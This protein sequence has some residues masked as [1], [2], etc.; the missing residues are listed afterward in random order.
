MKYSKQL[1]IIII[2]LMSA[3]LVGVLGFTY[4]SQD[5][6][7]SQ[8][9]VTESS[10]EYINDSI[11]TDSEDIEKEP[12][13][14]QTA[15]ESNEITEETPRMEGEAMNVYTNA[16]FPSL[17]L[18]YSESWSIKESSEDSIFYPGLKSTM[19][20]FRQGDSIVQVTF[21]PPVGGCGGSGATT[22]L[23]P[24]VE[25]VGDSEFHRYE[26]INYPLD[27]QGKPLNE[28]YEYFYT[29][30]FPSDGGLDPVC[31]DTGTFIATTY[32]NEALNS[33]QPGDVANY[34]Y[35]VTANGD[36]AGIL[37][38]DELVSGFEF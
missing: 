13:S 23:F 18:P 8:D 27:D 38:A 10:E 32:D 4:I 6:Q 2:L 16:G 14:E 9:S 21:A 12:D 25:N 33:G 31:K 37:E 35:F 26:N 7:A 36:E 19:V 3:T 34:N 11:R 20:Q 24:L 1:T 28:V 5:G 17:K 22:K 29:D 15:M 30:P